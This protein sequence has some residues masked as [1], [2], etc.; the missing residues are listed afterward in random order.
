MVFQTWRGMYSSGAAI[1]T[2]KVFTAVRRR[3]NAIQRSKKKEYRMRVWK[4]A[5]IL[6]VF[7]CAGGVHAQ[8]MDARFAVRG[9]FYLGNGFTDGLLH[10]HLEGF[11]IGGDIPIVRHIPGVGGLTFSPTI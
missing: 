4:F 10:T 1:G 5:A 11:E 7:F 8:E 6:A 3:R 9:G 2:M